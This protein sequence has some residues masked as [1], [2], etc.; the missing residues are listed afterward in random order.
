MKTVKLT[1][2]ISSFV[3]FGAYFQSF[4]KASSGAVLHRFLFLSLYLNYNYYEKTV[5]TLR[6]TGVSF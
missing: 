4:Y 5:P 6:E 1:S 3:F 2:S